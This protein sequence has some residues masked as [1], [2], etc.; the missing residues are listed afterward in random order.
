MCTIVSGMLQFD[1]AHLDRGNLSQLCSDGIS[2]LISDIALGLTLNEEVDASLFAPNH[3]VV[4]K[5]R[6][7]ASSFNVT[8]C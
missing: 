3:T 4:Q 7:L 5:L 2:L 1:E 8:K 6:T